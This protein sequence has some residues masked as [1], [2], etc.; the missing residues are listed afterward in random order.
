MIGG[1]AGG[2]K[3]YQ[4]NLIRGNVGTSRK[5]RVGLD[6]DES[7]LRALKKQPLNLIFFFY[8]TRLI[9]D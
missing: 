8:L 2:T 6:L 7:I 9:T 1:L 5:A 4:R 3:L